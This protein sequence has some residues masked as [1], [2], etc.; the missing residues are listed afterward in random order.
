MEC[1]E[2]E[3]KSPDFKFPEFGISANGLNNHVLVNI[4]Y[5]RFS[6]SWNRE[7]LECIV[8]IHP[9][10]RPEK[11][12]NSRVPPWEWLTSCFP[13]AFKHPASR[14]P[15][16]FHPAFRQRKMAY[17]ASRQTLYVRPS[18]SWQFGAIGYEGVPEVPFYRSWSEGKWTL[19]P[20]R[21]NLPR[22]HAGLASFSRSNHVITRSAVPVVWWFPHSGV[23]CWT[24]TRHFVRTVSNLLHWNV[25]F[26][27]TQHFKSK[28]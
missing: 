19:G 3:K 20:E 8:V 14:L 21:P 10:S 7:I 11:I 12:K 1:E 28:T 2:A 9:V 23:G 26:I 17:L 6:A 16:V 18:I 5:N 25:I 13:S 22:L 15:I 27:F 24:R 4:D